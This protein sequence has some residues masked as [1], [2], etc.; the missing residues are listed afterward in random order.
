MSHKIGIMHPNKRKEINHSSEDNRDPHH[1]EKDET[2]TLVPAKPKKYPKSRAP[3]PKFL[4]KFVEYKEL[5]S[6][7]ADVELAAESRIMANDSFSQTSSP[8]DD[9]V[10]KDETGTQV[11]AM[12][13]KYPKSRALAP[14]F[15]A[16][17]VEYKE[18]QSRSVAVE[19][20][21][22]SRIM[23]NESSSQTSSHFDDDS[24]S[25]R[26]TF[27]LSESHSSRIPPEFDQN[28]EETDTTG[29]VEDTKP[30]AIAFDSKE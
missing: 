15:L 5:Q 18:L 29:L 30:A 6:R 8:L 2:A 1:G 21:A 24:G 20:A 4:A 9:D 3:A 11:P 23:A 25:E 13:K 19:L 22:E 17:F 26:G 28:E 16:K 27:L 7:S 14:K 12:P 10:E